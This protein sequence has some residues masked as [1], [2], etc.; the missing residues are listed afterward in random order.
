PLEL[1]RSAVPKPAGEELLVRVAACTLCRSDLHTHAG[2]RN[3]ALPT[4]LGHEI[5][6]RIVEFGPT[7]S[8][9]DA[10]EVQVREGDR[11]TWA[12]VAG[13]GGCFY[14]KEDLP[15]KCERPYKYGHERVTK[16]RPFG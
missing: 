5:V 1:V 9:T 11:V 3:E 13:C 7:A 6:G 4:V 16:E 14:C 10:A 15:Q 2:R 8:R 12:V